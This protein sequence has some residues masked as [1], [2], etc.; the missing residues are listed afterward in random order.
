[1]AKA[2]HNCLSFSIVAK[3]IQLQKIIQDDHVLHSSIG[4]GLISRA[5]DLKFKILGLLS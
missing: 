3:V 1:M 4:G 2:V 5:V